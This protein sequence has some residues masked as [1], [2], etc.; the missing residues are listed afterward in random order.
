MD[1]EIINHIILVYLS[2]KCTEFEEKKLQSWINSSIENYEYFQKIKYTWLSTGQLRKDSD[3]DI[4]AAL[5][6]F[7]T[8]ISAKPVDEASHG[9]FKLNIHKTVI[10]KI[11]KYA[12]VIFII[13]SA[14]G[15]CS[16]F[17]FSN[18][19]KKQNIA[20]CYYEIP[21]GSKGKAILPDGTKVWL[22][23]GSKISYATDYN[24]QN[25]IVKLEG[26]GFFE[27][28]TN[29]KK[30]FIVKAKGLDIKAYGTAFNVKAYRD[31][32]EIIT[33]LVKGKVYIEGKDKQNKSFTIQMKPNQCITYLTDFQNKKLSYPDTKS[34]KKNMS[35]TTNKQIVTGESPLP[36]FTKNAVKT[37]LYTS[38]KE[39]RWEIENAN[40]LDFLKE[41]ER[42]Y[43]VTISI[44]SE[45][46][47][48]YPFSGT[49]MNENIEQVLSILRF[50]L[51][52]KYTIKKDK[53]DLMLD[54]ELKP[55]YI[56][57]M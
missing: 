6:N 24:A 42:R 51:P 49:I 11:L 10:T 48:K 43:N 8:A 23:A 30:P 18:I 40:L 29:A 33:T 5:N 38:W 36:F 17:M 12:A 4:E 47:K 20:T 34:D 50:A 37:E 16:L 46:L 57:A 39:N 22:N 35:E 14:G 7:Y 19:Q 56:Q 21:I 15:V 27:V 55:K 2:G 25:R 53:I 26:E 28:V 41:V 9:I 45:E 44:K 13:F 52:V 32:S 3:F 31:E 54:L 1:D